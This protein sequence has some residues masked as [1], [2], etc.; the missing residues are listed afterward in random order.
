[1]SKLERLIAGGLEES[2]DCQCGVEMRL[3][4]SMPV[5]GSTGAEIRTYACSVCRREFRL[6]VWDDADVSKGAG[7]AYSGS[8]I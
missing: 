5:G 2:P 4:E 7:A 8:G 1:M 6:T 3:I